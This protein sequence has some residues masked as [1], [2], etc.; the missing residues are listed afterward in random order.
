M[1][2]R[3]IPDKLTPLTPQEVA[4]AFRSALETLM[5]KT[6]SNAFLALLVA[7]SALETGR[8]KSIHCFNFGNVK[9]SPTYVGLYCQFRCNEVLKGKVVWFNP[10]HPQCNFRAFESAETGSID[11]IRFLSQSKRY[12]YAWQVA[13]TGMP[14]AFVDAL[15]HA[16]YF[17]AD[18]APYARA[19]ASLWKEYLAML[20]EDEPKPHLAEVSTAAIDRFVYTESLRIEQQS[21]ADAQR[22]WESANDTE[23]APPPD[24]AA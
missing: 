19:V 10:P 24:E 6:P 14:L 21:A 12:A 17:T 22:E 5:G 1:N 16:G 13:Q 15:K 11:H 4:L 7:Q 2:A 23:P 8:W 18:E 3:L 9:A 20:S